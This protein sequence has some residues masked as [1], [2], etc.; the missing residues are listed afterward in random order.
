MEL[1]NRVS[2]L[3]FRADA[4]DKELVSLQKTQ[5]VFGESLQ[6]IQQTLLQIKYALYGGGLV[7][8]AQVL[9]VKE[10]LLKF[11]H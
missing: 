1:D 11:I 2:L 6:S 4:Q 3:E 10:T 9:G 8:M 5:A 7:F